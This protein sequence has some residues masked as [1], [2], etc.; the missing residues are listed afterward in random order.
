MQLFDDFDEEMMIDIIEQRKNISIKISDEITKFSKEIPN[1]DFSS[2]TEVPPTKMILSREGL[3]QIILH[4][5]PDVRGR[6][7]RFVVFVY[8]F[9]GKIFYKKID[10]NYFEAKLEWSKA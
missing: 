8:A 10:E 2:E 1:V 5:T 9:G 4:T 3:A 6:F 7:T